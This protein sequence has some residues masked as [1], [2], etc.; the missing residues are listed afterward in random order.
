MTTICVDFGGTRLKTALI[1]EQTVLASRLTPVDASQG[2]HANLAD[3]EKE[4][5]RLAGMEAP[6]G[7]AV[8]FP[9]LVDPV[10]KKVMAVNGKYADA[11]GFDWRR[12]AQVH[13]SLPVVLENDANAALI[14]EVYAGCAKGCDNAVVMILGTGIGTAALINGSLLRGKHFQAGCLGGHISIHP[15]TEGDRCT[16]GSVGCAESVASGWALVKQAKAD[17]DYGNSAL[18]REETIDFRALEKWDA[19][20]DALAVRLMERCIGGWS[21]C[22][23]NLVHAYDPDILVLSGGVIRCGD[24][25]IRPIVDSVH[26]CPWTPWGQVDVRV[27]AQPEHSVVMGLHML[28]AQQYERSREDSDENRKL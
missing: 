13:F 24:R 19:A 8:A 7:L 16:C 15:I 11:P 25:I 27:A 22:A 4:I 26:R 3:V 18:S 5:A 10:A 6:D 12:W 17:P 21:T 23:V 20:G 28:Y 9:G 1:R 14:G 2:L